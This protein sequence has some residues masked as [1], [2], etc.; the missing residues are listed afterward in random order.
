[1]L[2]KIMEATTRLMGAERTNGKE[3]DEH[4]IGVNSSLT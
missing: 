1:M 4:E 3:M 2:L